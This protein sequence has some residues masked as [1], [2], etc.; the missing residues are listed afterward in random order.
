MAAIGVGQPHWKLVFAQNFR[1][2]HRE[3]TPKSIERLPEIFEKLVLLVSRQ[4][5]LG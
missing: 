3:N 5:A 2:E 1:F 4:P